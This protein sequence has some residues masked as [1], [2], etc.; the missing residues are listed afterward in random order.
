MRGNDN[1]EFAVPSI[2]DFHDIRY[3]FKELG[4]SPDAII[5]PY[6]LEASEYISCER[7]FM[8]TEFLV[9]PPLT[10]CIKGLIKATE[11]GFRLHIKYTEQGHNNAT[12]KTSLQHT[13]RLEN[14][15]I[16]L[17]EYSHDIKVLPLISEPRITS[18]EI[19]LQDS[20]IDQEDNGRRILRQSLGCNMEITA[21]DL[22]I[23]YDRIADLASI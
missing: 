2:D 17:T 3:A 9:W 12:W 16:K 14:S 21:G 7:L 19:Y 18:P 8:D 10:I 11:D 22:G 20:M 23:L 13:Y 1:P 15:G 5:K 6:D 4:E